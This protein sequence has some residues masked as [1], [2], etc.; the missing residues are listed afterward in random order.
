[1]LRNE[2]PF[3]HIKVEEKREFKGKFA[4]TR[5]VIIPEVRV[6]SIT[7]PEIENVGRLGYYSVYYTPDELRV[8]GGLSG[9]HHC[10]RPPWPWWQ[11]AVAS[12]VQ[13]CRFSGG[14]LPP[15]ATLAMVVGGGDS[16]YTLELLSS[17]Y[18]WRFQ[19]IRRFVV[20][21]SGLEITA[22]PVLLRKTNLRDS[23]LLDHFEFE[24]RIFTVARVSCGLSFVSFK[25]WLVHH[26]NW[27]NRDNGAGCP[28]MELDRV[29]YLFGK[30]KPKLN[31]CDTVLKV[32]GFT[33]RKSGHKLTRRLTEFTRSLRGSVR[34]SSPLRF[35]LSDIRIEVSS[36]TTLRGN[37]ICFTLAR[38]VVFMSIR[39]L[40]IRKWMCYVMFVC[41]LWMCDLFVKG[42]NALGP[43][44]FSLASRYRLGEESLASFLSILLGAV[45]LSEIRNPVDL[46]RLYQVA[47]LL[48]EIPLNC[49]ANF[50]SS[51]FEITKRLHVQSI[52]LFVECCF[53]R[54][55]VK[56]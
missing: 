40:S 1:M 28:G 10:H 11:W 51:T 31:A 44:F 3:P 2:A 43:I 30:Q 18:V 55:I 5:P 38:G 26:L 42:I 54:I 15:P 20:W 16:N 4:M 50:V 49:L 47:G 6:G 37:C 13:V 34:R 53:E 19:S 46:D 36:L 23:Y 45:F 12:H 56:D 7:H 35:Y 14:F 29:L 33:G 52:A 32:M 17:C 8:V 39:V 25:F 27:P 48:V 24:A 22:I 9:E 41:Y 21:S